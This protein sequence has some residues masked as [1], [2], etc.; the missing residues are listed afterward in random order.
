MWNDVLVFLCCVLFQTWCWWELKKRSCWSSDDVSQWSLQEVS[1]STHHNVTTYQ[2][3]R[4]YTIGGTEL[5]EIRKGSRGIGV[6]YH[7]WTSNYWVQT[8]T[9]ILQKV[10]IIQQIS[11][12][13]KLAISYKCFIM[14]DF[15]LIINYLTFGYVHNNQQIELK[16]FNN[17][18]FAV[19]SLKWRKFLCKKIEICWITLYCYTYTILIY[20]CLLQCITLKS[21]NQILIVFYYFNNFHLL[22]L[23]ISNN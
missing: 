6:K 12:F 22:K 20:I 15:H 3:S 4:M 19:Q 16:N 14:H 1:L 7:G 17:F 21:R 23:S 9:F 8:M 2:T 18:N 11:I 13:L 5:T 10:A